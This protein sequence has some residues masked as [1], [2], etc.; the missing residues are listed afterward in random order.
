MVTGTNYVL[1][2]QCMLHSQQLF[3]RHMCLTDSTILTK[4]H[5]LKQPNFTV[6]KVGKQGRQSTPA[7]ILVNI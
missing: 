7:D 6:S 3:I 4:A 2:S 5:A 1:L